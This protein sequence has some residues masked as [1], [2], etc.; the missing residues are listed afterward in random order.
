[1]THHDKVDKWHSIERDTPPVH[2][3]SQVGE[4]HSDGEDDHERRK[5]VKAWEDEADKEDSGQWHSQWGAYITP[6]G[7]VLLVEH[8]EHTAMGNTMRWCILILFSI[9]TH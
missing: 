2:E 8:I 7:Q 4:N 1:M 9:F 5:E 3:S 6:H